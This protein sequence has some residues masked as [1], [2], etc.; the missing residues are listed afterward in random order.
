M[1]ESLA[2]C[3]QALLQTNRSKTWCKLGYAK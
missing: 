2:V 3:D 1:L